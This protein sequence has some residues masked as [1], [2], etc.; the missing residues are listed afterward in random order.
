M[1][2]WTDTESIT[3]PKRKFR[4]TVQFTNV[5]GLIWW[6]KTATKPAFTIASAEHKY[7]NHTYYYPGSVSWSDVT[8]TMV[9]PTSPDMAATLSDIIASSGYTIPGQPGA[10]TDLA[11]ISKA[12]SVEAIGAVIITQIAADGSALETWTLHNAFATEVKYGDLEYGGDDL[13]EMSLTFKY[14][15][16]SCLAAG[17]SV[18][19]SG[20]GAAANSE[21][22]TV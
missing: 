6:A 1:S 20:T 17:A 22:F 9:D 4:F 18:L 5:E 19:K 3:D 14:D 12:K 10:L 16:A 21:F 7:L 13:T 11:T 8:V 15:W 2:F